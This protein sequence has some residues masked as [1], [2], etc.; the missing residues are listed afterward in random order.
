MQLWLFRREPHTKM[1]STQTVYAR[2]RF[3]CTAIAFIARAIANC[4]PCNAGRLAPLLRPP[5]VIYILPKRYFIRLTPNCDS[6]LQAQINELHREKKS[7]FYSVVRTAPSATAS[8]GNNV[9]C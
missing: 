4:L 8:C 7:L 2:W 5:P 6:R 1:N 3:A 9:C